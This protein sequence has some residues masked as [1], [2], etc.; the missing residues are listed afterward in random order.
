MFSQ[1]NKINDIENNINE[2]INDTNINS[3]ISNLLKIEKVFDVNNLLST[4]NNSLNES[5]SQNSILEIKLKEIDQ[6]RE[7][8][9]K[10]FSEKTKRCKEYMRTFYLDNQKH[11]ELFNLYSITVKDILQK[12]I[13]YNSDINNVLDQ[14]IEKYSE[15][16]N[17]PH[18]DSYPTNFLVQLVTNIILINN[19]KYKMNLLFK[20][21]LK[22]EVCRQ[23]EEITNIENINEKLQ[24]N[25]NILNECDE[26]Y[27]IIKNIEEYNNV[28]IKEEL[29][30]QLGDNI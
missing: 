6:K 4:L 8:I 19:N 14:Y 12:N 22:E 3:N 5:I 2:V 17:N 29:I 24:M 11:K 16:I 26:I 10:S 13:D 18:S 30:K 9:N 27:N 1:I 15:Y 25:M 7:G 23:I 28:N 20:N 21:A